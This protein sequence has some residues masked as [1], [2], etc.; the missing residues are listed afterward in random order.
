LNESTFTIVLFFTLR[1]IEVYRYRPPF[2][3]VEGREVEDLDLP[4]LLRAVGETL[5][6]DVLEW[7]RLGPAIHEAVDRVAN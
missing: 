6:P 4:L 3:L 1:E 7:A 2:P 5:D